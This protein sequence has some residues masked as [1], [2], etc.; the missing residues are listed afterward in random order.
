MKVFV[1]LSVLLVAASA[2]PEPPAPGGYPS[3]SAPSFS[4]GGDIGPYASSNQGALRSWEERQCVV[5]DDKDDEY[6]GCIECME[7]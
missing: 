4:S 3:Y 2:R 5:M 1:V 7:R 6:P